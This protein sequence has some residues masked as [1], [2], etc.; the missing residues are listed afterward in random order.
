MLLSEEE[1]PEG[2][3]ERGEQRRKMEGY[4]LSLH[5]VPVF[6]LQPALDSHPGYGGNKLVPILIM[7]DRTATSQHLLLQS[8]EQASQAVLD[9]VRALDTHAQIPE[10]FPVHDAYVLKVHN[11][12]KDEPAAAR[13]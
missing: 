1:R 3:E 5:Q 2:P 9:V 6:P 10:P 11:V 13:E 8:I 12:L 7:V 4:N